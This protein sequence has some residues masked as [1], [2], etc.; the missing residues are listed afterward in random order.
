MEL[1][2]GQTI[3]CDV[4]LAAT[5]VTPRID[6]ARAAELDLEQSR[7]AVDAHLR[8]SANDVYAAGDVAF[9]V[10]MDAGRRIAIEHWQD[11]ADQ[12]AVA[13]TGRGRAVRRI[14]VVC[15]GFGQQSGTRR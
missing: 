4:V 5:G 1:D 13:G 11:A 12:G 2:G 7:I 9:A 6:L 15:R 3:G 14:G 8:A 10:N